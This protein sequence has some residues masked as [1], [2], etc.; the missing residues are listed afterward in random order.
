[1]TSGSRSATERPQLSIVLVLHNSAGTLSRCLRSIE[2]DVREGFA[3]VI[4]VDNASPDESAR[5]VSELL[6]E[7]TLIRSDANRLFAGGANLAF[8]LLRGKYWMLLNPDVRVPAGALKRLVSWMAEHREIGAGS[9]DLVTESGGS[10]CP[11]RRLPSIS[12]SL[13]EMSRLHRLL[14]EATRG[15]ILLGHYARGTPMIEAEYVPA[16]ALLIRPEVVAE[17][18]TLSES[19]AFYGEDIEWCWRIRRAGWRIAVCTRVTFE[20]DEGASARTTWGEPARRERIWR[21]YY[22]ACG[23]I[24]GHR[25]ARLLMVVNALAFAAESAIRR[26]RGGSWRLPLALARIHLRLLRPLPELGAAREGSALR[27]NAD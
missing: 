6:P 2:T 19:V 5:L 8:P 16:T 24:R 27:A 26:L 10:I 12:R 20:H 22:D 3:E 13:L 21:G 18:G 23:Q 9:P 25:Y 15:R 11:A 17:V 7:A 1:M 14:P 4:A